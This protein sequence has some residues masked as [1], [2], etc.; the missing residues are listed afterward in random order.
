M[1]LQHFKEVFLQALFALPRFLK[2]PIQGMRDLPDWDW[3]ILI[4]LQ[5]SL[6]LVTGLLGAVLTRSLV[7][8]VTSVFIAPISALLVNA[9]LSGFF[10]YTFLILFKRQISFRFIVTHMLFASIPV[11]VLNIAAS[12]IPLV[13]HIG[14][15]ASA[16]LLYVGFRENLHLN[17]LKLRILMGSLVTIYV[18]V[19]VFQMVRFHHPDKEMKIRATPE[20]LD[21]LEQ[22]L[23]GLE[24]AD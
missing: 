2:N 13:G 7:H 5:A 23:R 9:I 4:A 10:Y 15:L 1:T 22:E 11:L 16:V 6:G 24:S 3:P 18:G 19:F 14:M 8:M 21:I 20:S 17:E 12:I